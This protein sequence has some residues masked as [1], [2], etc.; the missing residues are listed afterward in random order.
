MY[1]PNCRGDIPVGVRFCNHCGAPVLSPRDEEATRVAGHDAAAAG[2]DPEATRFA[3]RSPFDE[4][5]SPPARVEQIARREEQTPAHA[6]TEAPRGEVARSADAAHHRGPEE[7]GERVVFA[8]RPTFLFI[9]LGYVLAALG[10]VGLTVLLAT[11]TAFPPH[12]SLL[13]ALP[14]LLIPAFRHLKRNS[15]RYTLT[16]SK[17]EIDQGFISRRTRNI[18]LRNIQDVTVSATIP[19]RLLGF[20]DIIIDNASEVGGSTQMRNV[21]DPRRH[22]DLLLREL[23]RW[24]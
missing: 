1:C 11:F 14:L 13:V 2:R 20:G 22:A 24:S 7:D 5:P 6:R 12:Y 16:D 8:V 23:R 3:A 15:V 17:I 10:A 18:P 9:G 19:Q 4:R 21:P